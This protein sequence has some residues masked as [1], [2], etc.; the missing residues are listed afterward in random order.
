MKIVSLTT[1]YNFRLLPSCCSVANWWLT[2]LGP[3]ECN[4]P[5]FPVTQ[6]L[7]VCANYM[8]IAPVMPS[9][10]TL[11]CRPHLLRPSIFPSIVKMQA[12]YRSNV[13]PIKIVRTFSTE[14]DQIILNCVR[15]H[16]RLN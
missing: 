15:N 11:L 5:D 2:L 1:S 4:T 9:K 14:L 16:E 12:I 6:H 7:P 8:S 13:I 10:H 3:M